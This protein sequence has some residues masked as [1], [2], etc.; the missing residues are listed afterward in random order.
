MNNEIEWV[1]HDGRSIAFQVIGTGPPDLLLL[2]AWWT[3]LDLEWDDPFAARRLRRLA[4]SARVIRF[5][6]SGMGL[7]DRIAPSPASAL[8]TWADEAVAVL[9][10]AN[11]RISRLL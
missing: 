4:A 8:D 5:H 10:A 6:K 9:N 1:E 3:H 2:D 11:V 7:S